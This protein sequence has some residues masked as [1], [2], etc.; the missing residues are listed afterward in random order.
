MLKFRIVAVDP[1]GQNDEEA[2]GALLG[3]MGLVVISLT[4]VPVTPEDIAKVKEAEEEDD[5]DDESDELEAEAELE[6]EEEL[7]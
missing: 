7:E 1:D 2:L 5:V 4:R 6:D 3:E